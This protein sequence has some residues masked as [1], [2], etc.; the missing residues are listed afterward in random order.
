M[1]CIFS[2]KIIMKKV[3]YILFSCIMIAVSLYLC[4]YLDKKTYKVDVLKYT[5]SLNTSLMNS[6]KIEKEETKEE[7]VSETIEEQ[8]EIVVKEQ[9]KEVKKIKE[10]QEIV[11]EKQE[12]TP[13]STIVET[14]KEEIKTGEIE[15]VYVGLRFQGSMSAYGRDCCGSN[16][17]M[18]SSGFDLKTSLYYYDNT[19]GN[20][21]VLASDKNFKLYSVIKINDPIDGQYNAIVLDRAGSVIGLNKTKKFDLAVE[22]ESF[23]AN[24]YGIHRNVTFE[25]LRV[26][27]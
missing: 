24:S 3:V 5:K 16:P 21:R 1:Q 27:R 12:T 18:T 4:I 19:Y 13:A 8:E 11:E 23:A 22:S 7:P 9:T 2:R 10:K 17:G 25:V 20:L 15:S 26:G 6:I 14:P